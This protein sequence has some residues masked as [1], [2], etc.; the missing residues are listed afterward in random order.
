YFR[1]LNA[2]KTEDTGKLPQFKKKLKALTVVVLRL[3]VD[4]LELAEVEAS[5]NDLD[6]LDQVDTK[7]FDATLENPV[8]EGGQQTETKPTD[9]VGDDQN[10]QPGQQTGARGKGFLGNQ[11]QRPAKPLPT[12]PVN[13]PTQPDN[14]TPTQPTADDSQPVAD[15]TVSTTKP[16]QKGGG[17]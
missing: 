13:K 5:D 1:F 4:N 7:E 6:Q 11:R 15:Q 17:G 9:V 10:Q 12:P 16:A 14:S 2:S 3:D 8:G